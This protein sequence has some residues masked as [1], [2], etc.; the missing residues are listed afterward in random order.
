MAVQNWYGT[1]G[2]Q[3]GS[4]Q[5]GN[6]ILSNS[7]VD[8]LVQAMA[9]FEAGYSASHGGLAFD[10]TRAGAIVDTTVLAAVNNVWHQGA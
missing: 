7:Q 2:A 5:A 4:I 10:P 8:A 6:S 3:L 9:T 1:P